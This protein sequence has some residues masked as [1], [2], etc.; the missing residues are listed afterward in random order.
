[1]NKKEVAQKMLDILK[2]NYNHFIEHAIFRWD[3]LPDE[4]YFFRYFNSRK[5]IIFPNYKKMNKLWQ[6]NEELFNFAEISRFKYMLNITERYTNKIDYIM[7]NMDDLSYP[8]DFQASMREVLD[9]ELRKE[10]MSEEIYDKEKE[11]IMI[12]REILDTMN[13]VHNKLKHFKRP[14]VHIDMSDVINYHKCNQQ[15]LMIIV[16]YTKINKLMFK[17][18]ES[19]TKEEKKKLI[20]LVR[21]FHDYFKWVCE[22]FL[23]ECE[24]V[25]PEN[26]VAILKGIINE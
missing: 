16:D 1:M 5:N 4:E 2:E 21:Y 22:M 25:Y 23:I 18:F 19:L 12:A 3:K 9:E 13:S 26:L 17:Y 24:V 6:N 7:V 15:Y 14:Q 8:T 11:K 10:Y 20:D